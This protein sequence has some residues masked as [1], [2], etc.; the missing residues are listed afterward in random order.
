MAVGSETDAQLSGLRTHAC[1]LGQGYYFS[2]P[3]ESRDAE[4]HLAGSFSPSAASPAGAQAVGRSV[5]VAPAG[6]RRG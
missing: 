5:A 4:I 2:R 3:L 1:T 6:H